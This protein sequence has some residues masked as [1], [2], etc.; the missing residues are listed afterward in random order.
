M[1][2]G[3]HGTVADM[4]GRGVEFTADVADH[5]DGFVTSFKAPG[6]ITVQ[7]YEPKYRKG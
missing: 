7:L 2:R 6:G 1:I 5:G 4:K 3:I